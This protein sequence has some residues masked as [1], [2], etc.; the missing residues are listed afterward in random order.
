MIETAGNK[1]VTKIYTKGESLM[2]MGQTLSQMAVIM[3]GTASGTYGPLNICLQPGAVIGLMDSPAGSCVIEYTALENLEVAVFE[4]KDIQDFKQFFVQ[5]DHYAAFTMEG[6]IRALGQL[7]HAYNMQKI[8]IEQVGKYVKRQYKRYIEICGQLGCV[9]MK[10]AKLEN[11]QLIESN[12]GELEELK[13]Y[14]KEL[15]SMNGKV[16]KEFFESGEVIVMRH[17]KGI[18]KLAMP[19][20]QECKQLM[21]SITEML[22]LL[23]GDDNDNVFTLYMTLLKNSIASRDISRE[24]LISLK[25]MIELR[26]KV[27]QTMVDKLHLQMATSGPK[28]RRS[29]ENIAEI[30]RSSAGDNSGDMA[31]Q[32]ENMDSMDNIN[33]MLDKILDYSKLGETDTEDFREALQQYC[34]MPDRM[35]S[36]NQDRMLRKKLTGLFYKV[37]EAVYFRAEKE[38]KQGVVL[39][40]FLNYGI[41]DETMFQSGTLDVLLSREKDNGKYPIRVYSMREWLH[42]IYM[43]N[44]E[45]SRNEFDQDYQEY[46]RELNKSKVDVSPEEMEKLN[47]KEEKVRFEI[48]NFFV[49]NNRLTSGRIL[50]FCPVMTEEDLGEG[51]ANQMVTSKLINEAF[52]KIL[53]IDFS[54]FH[55]DVLYDDP[56][57]GITKLIIHQQVM[58]DVVLMPNAGTMGRM[59]QEISGRKRASAGRFTVPVVLKEDILK[60]TVRMIGSFRWEICKRVQGNYWNDV[61]EPSLTS[62]FCDYIQFYKKNRELSD[63]AKEKLGQLLVK[64]RNNY[65]ELFVNNYMIWIISESAGNVRLDKVTR[66]IMGRYCPFV[67]TIRTK[68]AD[69]PMFSEAI[70]RYERERMKRVKELNNR[71]AVIRNC[72]G[73]ETIEFLQEIEYWEL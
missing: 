42:E 15:S 22:G 14:Y 49:M 45:P 43:G 56:K 20:L 65:G 32:I 41:V 39:D 19:L 59:W 5:E 40:L 67:R 72:S 68:L 23:C 64:C 66:N 25:A 9:P 10:S 35:S 13:Q 31:Q 47:S 34:N 1:A 37:Y 18:P 16:R 27:E 26:E 36:D 53:S 71:R 50:G 6:S 12:L 28:F 11:I 38:C 60:V 21:T 33:G 61:S 3:R 55:R 30:Y 51:F 57:N 4:Y 54:V 73:T 46:L 7:I 2:P 48:K 58:P 29:Y 24:L 62:E 44:K 8:M 17:L 63:K 70:N 52:K 69:Q